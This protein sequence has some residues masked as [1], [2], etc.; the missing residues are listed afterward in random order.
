MSKENNPDD[1]QKKSF[2]QRHGNPPKLSAKK[3]VMMIG[4]VALFAAVW[5]AWIVSRP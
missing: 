4:M 5:I 2:W 1:T 3:W